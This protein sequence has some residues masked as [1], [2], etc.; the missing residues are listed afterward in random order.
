KAEL[1]KYVKIFQELGIPLLAIEL[2][3]FSMV[4]GLMATGAVS[5]LVNEGGRW[6]LLTVSDNSFFTA[7][8]EGVKIQK[9]ADAWLSVTEEDS[10]STTTQ[11]VQQDFEAFVEGEAFEKLILVNNANRINS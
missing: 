11:E 4:R 1:E 5:N 7:I 8:L 9:T 6:C 3:Y 2:N 10:P